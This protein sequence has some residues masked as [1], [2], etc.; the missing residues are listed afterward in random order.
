M[1]KDPFERLSVQECHLLY[2]SLLQN[3]DRHIKAAILIAK[4]EEY[5]IANAHLTIAA[6]EYIKALSVYLTGWGLPVSRV[7]PCSAFFSPN[8]TR[9]CRIARRSGD[10]RIC[11]LAIPSI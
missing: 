9:L 1:T 4:T 11:T 10:G 5:G 2:P 8:K 3:A 7:K 6:E